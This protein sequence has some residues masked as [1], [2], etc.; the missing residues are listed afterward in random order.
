MAIF[1]VSQ[2]FEAIDQPIG[3]TEVWF[4]DAANLADAHIKGAQIASKRT[5]ILSAGFKITFQRASG[6]AQPGTPGTFRQRNASLTRIGQN[7]SYDSSATNA[8]TAWQAG[9][10]RFQDSS[11]AIFRVMLM[12]GLPDDFWQNGDD[13]KA[14]SAFAAFLP[15]F[16]AI[17]IANAAQIMH[18][19]RGNPLRAP[20]PVAKGLFERLSKRDS[21]RP[22]FGFRGRKAKRKTP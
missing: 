22:S 9:Q 4:L 3:W 10:V 11:G 15:G 5:E 19:Q 13:K 2:F 18:V 7:G 8:D 16:T 14:A 17:L 1:K 20:T 21:G 12:R 6:N